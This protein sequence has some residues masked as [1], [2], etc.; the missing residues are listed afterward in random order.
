MGG[1]RRSRKLLPIRSDL[2]KEDC[3]ELAY[4]LTAYFEDRV[5]DIGFWDALVSLHKRKFG[6]RL[7]FFD[8][9]R[10]KEE[11]HTCDDIF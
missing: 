4:N 8:T 6:K 10:L 9:E 1:L 3:R 2:S 11:E 7:P 5:N